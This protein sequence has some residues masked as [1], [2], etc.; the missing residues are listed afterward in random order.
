MRPPSPREQA[1]RTRVRENLLRHWDPAWPMPNAWDRLAKW[2][3]GATGEE[4]DLW[5][6]ALIDPAVRRL[7][8]RVRGLELLE[9]GCGNG[10][11]AR[12][13]A[14]AGATTVVGLDASSASVRFARARERARPTGA[15]FEAGDAS[16]LRFAD[17]SFDLV[18]ANMA[19]MDIR[20]ARGAF[21]EAAR[22]LVPG[23]RLVFSVCHPCFDVDER[24]S[25][26]VER[27]FDPLTRTF[28]D[29]VFRKVH[30]YRDERRIL[31][32]WPVGRGKVVW[33]ES[34]HRT[35]TTYSR[36]L[37]DAGLLIARLEEPWPEAEMLSK[38]VQGPYLREIPLHLVVEAVRRPQA[39]R[40]S[41]TPVRSRRATAPRSGSRDRTSGSGSARR[42]SRTGS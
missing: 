41:R 31:T 28:R 35:L 13:F 40:G 25:W 26:S 36:Y 42:G 39:T 9:V 6:R 1:R 16:H 21:A 18:V 29:T 11:L 20:D 10:Y 27:G 37:H 34:Y 24:T 14:S 38:S 15:R 19:L 32:P 7:V 12:A 2:R 17:G 22:V 5:H 8:G 33:T 23:G 3:D 4:G 30:G